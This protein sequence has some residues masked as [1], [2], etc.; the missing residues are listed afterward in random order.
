MPSL[1]EINSS[2]TLI[3]DFDHIQTDISGIP[4]LLVIYF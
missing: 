3:Y 1:K 4:D 2:R